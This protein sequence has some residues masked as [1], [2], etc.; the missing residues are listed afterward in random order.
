[1]D[2]ETR[3]RGGV[4]YA[5]HQGIAGFGGV[6]VLAVILSSIYRLVVNDA[7]AWPDVEPAFN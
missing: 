2:P 5:G 1:M 3:V 6:D 4:H 7:K